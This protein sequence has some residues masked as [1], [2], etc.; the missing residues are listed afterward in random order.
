MGDREEERAV[1]K[2]DSRT[3]FVFN[4]DFQIVD[5]IVDD[6][7]IILE[8]GQEP[9]DIEKGHWPFFGHRG[10]YRNVVV[11]W[12]SENK[13][14]KLSQNDA[15]ELFQKDF[16]WASYSIIARNQKPYQVL[17]KLLK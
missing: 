17:R 16:P 5:Q 8:N 4:K 15:R 14:L 10:Y 7:K 13:L 2:D 12:A 1:Y 3:S 11:P 6:L 9:S